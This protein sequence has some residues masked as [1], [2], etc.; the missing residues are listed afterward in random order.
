MIKRST[1]TEMTW[2]K[3][4][5][6]GFLIIVLLMV[7]LAWIPSYFLYW[8]SARDLSAQKIIQEIVH[9]IPGF[10]HHTDQPYT[11]TRVRDAIA[12]GFETTVLA[13]VLAVAYITGEKKRRRLGQRG[14]DDVKGYLPGK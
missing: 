13:V 12:M 11:S 14:S 9:R 7:F 10:A 2:A 3:A 1:Q 5:L 6:I 4:V 8:W